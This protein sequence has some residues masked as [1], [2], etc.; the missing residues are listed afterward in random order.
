MLEFNGTDIRV[1][2]ALRRKSGEMVL[3]LK[4]KTDELSLR[5]VAK[6]VGEKLHGQIL[7]QRSGLLAGSV[8]PILAEISGNVVSGGVTAAGG[9]AFYGKVHEEGGTREYEIVPVN[10]KSLRFFLDNKERFFK[11]VLHPPLKQRSLFSR[12][13][14]RCNLKLNASWKKLCSSRG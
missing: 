11:R 3:A 13:R 5:L 8:R 1:L 7:Q 14:W 12:Q 9:P 10:K 6:I 2:T 4:R